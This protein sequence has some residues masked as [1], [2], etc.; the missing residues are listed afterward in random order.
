MSK[1]N[2]YLI[3]T[4]DFTN[5]EYKSLES[6][7]EKVNGPLKFITHK[8]LNRKRHFDET[9]NTLS[10]EQLFSDCNEFRKSAEK[11]TADDFVVLLTGKNN[12]GDYFSLFDPE[13][14]IFVHTAGWDSFTSAAKI[15]P[16][17][18]EI[19]SNILQSLMK[20]K[21]KL[22][23]PLTMTS[24]WIHQNPIGCINDF[25]GDKKEIILKLRTADTCQNC[26]K[27]MKK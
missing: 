5:K 25:C 9:I 8:T 17:A 13:K 22:E 27:E 23:Q 19:I 26:L 7:L 1:I 18:Y 24:K 6:F 3:N 20:M 14:N 15:Y 16:I 11:V 12:H 10:W 4:T 2:I 21:L